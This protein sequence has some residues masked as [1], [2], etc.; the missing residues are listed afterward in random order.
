MK[1]LLQSTIITAM[2]FYLATFIAQGLQVSGNAFI[3][4]AA[5]FIFVITTAILKPLFSLFAFPFAFL[6]GVIV[7]LTS[8]T[9]A[10]YIVSLILKSVKISAFTIQEVYFYGVTIPEIKV[11]ALLSYVVISVIIAIASKIISWI[12]DKE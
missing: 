3:F 2:S 5:G 12:F 9:I 4:F 6:S 8:N 1:S 7:I 11:G 10:L